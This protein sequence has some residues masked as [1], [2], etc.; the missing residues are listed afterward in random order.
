MDWRDSWSL[1]GFEIFFFIFPDVSGISDNVAKQIGQIAS[2]FWPHTNVQTYVRN[3]K[4]QINSVNYD[5]FD[6]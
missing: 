4:Y 2:T 3:K 6:G 1:L 5:S